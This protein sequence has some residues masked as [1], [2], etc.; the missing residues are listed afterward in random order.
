MSSFTEFT[1]HDAIGL[2]ELVR[3]GE[4]HPTE[5]V[6]AAIE[7]IERYN[8]ALNAVI[9]KLY[10][11][12]RAAA[13]APLGDGPFAG[14]PFLLKDTIA[15]AG[16]TLSMGSVLLR[17]NVA[18]ET[19]A[20]VER[21]EKAGLIIVGRT[22]LCEL[23]LLP[24]SE[25]LLYGE[26][27]NPWNTGHSPAGSSGGSAAAVAARMVPM[28]HGSDGGGSIRI[29]AGACGVFGLK[30]SRG[31]NPGQFMEDPSG[32]VCI[33]GLTI[34]V[35][36]S[37]A[38]LDAIQ[39]PLPGDLWWAPPPARPYTEEVRRDPE[40]LRIGF[41]TSDYSGRRSHP[42]CVEAVE[43][44]AKL[45]EELGHSVEEAKPDIDGERYNESFVLLW[46]TLAGG[47]F[48]FA[49]QKIG[50]ELVPR[51]LM[52]LVGEKRGFEL[53]TRIDSL[54]AGAAS[55]APF[56]RTL[57]E[58]ET[59]STPS[60]Y[61][62]ACTVMREAA[63]ELARF[64]DDHDILLTPVAGTPPPK[65]GEIG[66][67]IEQV[68][69]R[70]RTLAYVGYTQL[71]NTSGV[72][73]MSMPL[74]WNSAGLPIGVQLAAPFGDEATLFQLAGQLEQARPWAGRLPPLVS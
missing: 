61:W 45:C 36:D 21:M 31:R 40:K 64:F 37:A 72:P 68:E 14:V 23:G 38:L 8:P 63:Y 12:G 56:T 55:L 10:D 50:E 43:R 29:P 7:R 71:C 18:T 67:R 47:L 73:A 2:A 59:K 65:L 48:R 74:H 27:K 58:I 4:V 53:L 51:T 22:N 54:R 46:A 13:R 69:L 15:Y 20:V 1:E 66:P 24:S 30:P 33:H 26:T 35:R 19:H 62:V 6:E 42:D 5:L 17:D 32:I 41:A 52:R 70:Q 49:A 60:D 57:A 28:A 25:S 44:T 11:K 3:K 9:D 34:S 39:G 16:C